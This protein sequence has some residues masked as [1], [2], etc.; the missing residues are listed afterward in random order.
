MCAGEM[1]KLVIAIQNM[2]KQEETPNNTVGTE[3]NEP[4]SGDE[5]GNF[6]FGID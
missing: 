5:V 2:P 3:N 1:M 6:F 4:P